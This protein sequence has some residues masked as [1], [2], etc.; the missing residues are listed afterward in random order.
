MTSNHLKHGLNKI[1]GNHSK[2]RHHKTTAAIVVIILLILSI[3]L[4]YLWL[5]EGEEEPLGAQ[6]V[7][8]DLKY[9]TPPLLPWA[10][11]SYLPPDKID[12]ADN[13]AKFVKKDLSSPQMAGR[14]AVLLRAENMIAGWLWLKVKQGGKESLFPLSSGSFLL[15]NNAGKIQPPLK[16]YWGEGLKPGSG[17]YHYPEEEIIELI[18]QA[19]KISFLV[20]EDTAFP[21]PKFTPIS[22]GSP[23]KEW[24]FNLN[25]WLYPVPEKKLPDIDLIDLW[26]PPDPGQIRLEGGLENHQSVIAFLKGE[27]E[28]ELKHI[29]LTKGVDQKFKKTKPE[30]Q[31]FADE[32]GKI[33]KVKISGRF[34]DLSEFGQQYRLVIGETRPYGEEGRLYNFITLSSF[35]GN[36]QYPTEFLVDTQSLGRLNPLPYYDRIIIGVYQ[37]VP[38]KDYG[39]LFPV[40]YTPYTGEISI[41]AKT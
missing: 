4:A 16:E 31:L 33:K 30:V 5:R 20:E 19:D 12:S 25:Q 15:P 28:I 39:Y 26:E 13:L 18:G 3:L 1:A 7:K 37:A 34:P 29:W 2:P 40:D 17:G 21:E 14:G 8:V 41:Q 32:A 10:I 23:E 36:N 27:K 9:D 6:T 22:P 11:I 24:A 35:Q 38:F